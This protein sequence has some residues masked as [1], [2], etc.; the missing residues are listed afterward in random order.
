LIISLIII[1]I[2]LSFL[3]D[4]LVWPIDSEASTQSLTQRTSGARLFLLWLVF[5]LSLV[6]YMVPLVIAIL[7]FGDQ[8]FNSVDVLAISGAFM[9]ILGRAITTIGALTLRSNLAVL[10]T[11]SIFSIS[12]NPISLGMHMTFIGLIVICDVWW[13]LLAFAFY[14][15]NIDL[16]ITLEE[17]ALAEKFGKPYL[18]Y[19]SKTSKYLLI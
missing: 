5:I 7:R 16:K 13:L 6:G 9:A 3:L 1:S 8:D 12:R 10:K 4:F 19:K 17:K 14:V 11:A 18:D 2:Y 15:I